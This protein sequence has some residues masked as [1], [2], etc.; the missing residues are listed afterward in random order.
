MPPT[1][2]DKFR[3]TADDYIMECMVFAHQLYDID[4]SMAL[5]LFKTMYS[6]VHECT[7]SN[8]LAY[9]ELVI[10]FLQSIAD[11]PPNSSSPIPEIELYQ[12]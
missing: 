10:Y 3:L 7:S 5:E 2:N 6:A 9:I 1:N 12:I 11:I 4:K 8:E